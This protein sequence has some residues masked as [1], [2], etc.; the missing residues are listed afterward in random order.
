MKT[1]HP[2]HL[3]P[4]TARELEVLALVAEGTSNKIIGAS[5]FI[6]EATVKKH[7]VAVMQKLNARDHT[8]AVVLAHRAGLLDLGA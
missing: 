5:M 4:L 2:G 6:S 7:L 3:Q 8:H 1:T